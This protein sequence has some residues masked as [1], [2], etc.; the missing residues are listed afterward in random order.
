MNLIDTFDTCALRNCG[1]YFCTFYSIFLLF[2]LLDL[3]TCHLIYSNCVFVSN[4]HSIN[5]IKV[6]WCK[7]WEHLSKCQNH[8]ES[9]LWNHFVDG[10]L[11]ENIVTYMSQTGIIFFVNYASTMAFSRNKI[12]LNLLLVF[13]SHWQWW[14]Q[15]TIVALRIKLKSLMYQYWEEKMV[16]VTKMVL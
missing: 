5:W 9:L 8:S 1:L 11:A 6:Q 13:L 3:M 7:R 10:D 14:L 4:K 2:H 15:E 12:W 16:F